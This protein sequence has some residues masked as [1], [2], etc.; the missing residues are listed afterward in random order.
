MPKT[1]KAALFAFQ[2]LIDLVI[3]S[4]ALLFAWLTDKVILLPVIIGSYAVLR[5]S[6]NK[7]YHDNNA[8]I[9]VGLSIIMVALMLRLALPVEFSLLSGVIVA[10]LDCYVLFI[11]KDYN[12]TKRLLQGFQ[13]PQIF[14]CLKCSEA[15]LLARCNELGFSAAN[16][17]LAIEFF[18]KKTPHKILADR[19]G[20]EVKTVTVRKRRMR[21]KLNG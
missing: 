4:V 13:R 10:V 11:A 12:D 16:K 1:I 9:C 6:F 8:F 15:E 21:D 14:N 5:Y 19:L 2:R 7:T 3:L 17:E 20:V 18:I